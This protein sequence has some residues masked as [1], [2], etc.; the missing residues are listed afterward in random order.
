[1][2][3]YG[4]IRNTVAILALAAAG[5]V[6]AKAATI[7]GR[8]ATPDGKGVAEA[9]VFVSA[10]VARSAP[11]ETPRAE[12]NQVDKTFVP[13]VLPI[14]AGTRVFFP[15]SD[16]I[17][18]HVYSFSRTKSFELPL[19]RGEEAPPVVFDKPGLVKLGCNIHDW[20]SAVILVLPS[21]HFAV[22]DA[23]GRYALR[24]LPAGEYSLVAWHERSREKTEESTRKVTVSSAGV[25]VDFELSL[26]DER[27]RPGRHGVRSDP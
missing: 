1:M 27:K 7:S 5:V 12:M 25:V 3:L 24:D 17:Q 4:R 26:A 21:M 14:V 13:A 18:H 23:D 19:Y 6:D 10:P 8:V 11:A 16:Q 15:N 20:M 9:V 22:T 2:D